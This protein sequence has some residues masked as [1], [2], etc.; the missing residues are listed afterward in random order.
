MSQNSGSTVWQTPLFFASSYAIWSLLTY[1]LGRPIILVV[2]SLG[3]LVSAQVGYSALFVLLKGLI[4]TY[5]VAQALL[6][7]DNRAESHTRDV[8]RYTRRIAFLGTPHEGAEKAK[9]AEMGRRFVAYL[10]DTN[11]ELVKD[12]EKKS[13]KLSEL[14]RE[15]PN[16]LRRRAKTDNDEI[17]II[18]FFEGKNMKVA[19][20]N[21]GKVFTLI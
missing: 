15:F 9:W 17:E 6:S 2:H 12:L 18:C 5:T 14:G 8:S 7:A 20:N 3:G 1:L 10:M 19:G 11:K 13:E 4:Q 21:I 16:L